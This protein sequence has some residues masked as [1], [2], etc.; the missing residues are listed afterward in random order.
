[1]ENEDW[2]LSPWSLMCRENKTSPRALL[3]S[4]HNSCFLVETFIFPFLFPALACWE[5]FQNAHVPREHLSGHVSRTASYYGAPMLCGLPPVKGGGWYTGKCPSVL[6][7]CQSS[8]S[9][10]SFFF[11]LKEM[12]RAVDVPQ[13]LSTCLACARPGFS[14]QN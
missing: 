12:N 8:H 7:S 9:G 5:C 4:Q 3:S 2:P 1:M 14:L 10:F 11:F 6:C 13:G